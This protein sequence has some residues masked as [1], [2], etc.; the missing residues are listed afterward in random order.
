MDPL[1]L[2]VASAVVSALATDAWQQARD[3]MV[4]LW[5]Q[6][7][8]AHVPAIEAD[9]DDTHAEIAAAPGDAA[10]QAL[11]ADWELKLRRLVAADPGV[12]LE[13]RRVLDEELTP[14]LPPAEQER[15][16]VVQNIT[17]DAPGAVAQGVA[18]GNLINYGQVPGPD[19]EG[20]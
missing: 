10:E 11:V 2:A 15:I 3:A 8:P 13:L 17:A 12:A 19:E 4:R 7:R 20:Q 6:A 14:L 18:F 9:L 1:E 5:R 16:R